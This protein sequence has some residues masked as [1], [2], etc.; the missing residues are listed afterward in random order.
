MDLAAIAAGA[1]PIAG[2]VVGMGGTAA[3]L[4]ADIRRDG[5]QMRDLG[6]AGISLAGDLLS[7]LPGAGSGI[8]AAK[9]ATKIKKFAKPLM[10]I[11]SMYGAVSAA[12]LVGKLMKNGSLTAQE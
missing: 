1:A 12:P 11:M 2:G 3:G 5:F 7:F 10:Q 4:V 8:Q 9:L 6:N